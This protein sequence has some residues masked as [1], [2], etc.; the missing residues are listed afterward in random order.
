MNIEFHYYTVYYLARCAGFPDD[1]SLILAQ[2]SQMVDDA[3]SPWEIVSKVGRVLTETTQ[4]YLFWNEDVART[5]YRPFHFIPGDRSLAASRR[6][7]GNPGRN[8]VT[9]DSPL[10]RELL[11]TALNTRDLYRIGIALHAYA[12]TWAHQN[13]SAEDEPQNA[14][15]GNLGV[16]AVGHLHAL[17]NPDGPRLSWTD[18]RLREPYRYVKNTERFL[19]AAKMMYRF[20]ATYMRRRFDD[21]IF[22]TGKLEDIWGTDVGSGNSSR[23][24]DFLIQLDVPPYETDS[25]ALQAG[26]IPDAALMRH[27]DPFSAGYSRMAWLANATSRARAALGARKGR[28]SAENFEGSAFERWNLAARAHRESCISCFAQRGIR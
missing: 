20:L 15:E 7:D 17:K 12:D 22:V 27:Q 13:F 5:I 21:D 3:V 10:A 19:G 4:N 14:L 11:I 28:I 9:E 8:A 16:P 6:L 23:A 26:A 24:A 25:L 2:S 18:T 1:Q